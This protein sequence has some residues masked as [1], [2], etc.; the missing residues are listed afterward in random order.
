MV[1]EN[2]VLFLSKH[3]SN[4]GIKAMLRDKIPYV[5]NLALL[6]CRSKER[7]IQHVYGTQIGLY[8]ET[9]VRLHAAARILGIA[10]NSKFEFHSTIDWENLS[11]KNEEHW[12]H[13]ESWVNWF[14][15]NYMYIQNTYEISKENGKDEDSIKLELKSSYLSSLDPAWQE[16]LAVFLIDSFKEH[17]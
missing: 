17:E 8:V 9:Y 14:S 16:K 1:R 10:P 5:V 4:K 12:K 15:Q 11:T 7:W 13:V 3:M 2:S 6:W